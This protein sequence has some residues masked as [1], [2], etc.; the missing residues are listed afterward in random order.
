MANTA[1]HGVDWAFV[2]AIREAENGPF[3]REFGVE[4]NG[5][6]GYDAQLEACTATVTHRLETYPSNPLVRCYGAD[7]FSRIRYTPSFI[8]YFASVWAPIG[9]DNDPESL[10]RNWFR[11]ASNAYQRFV[12]SD[13]SS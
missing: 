7:G 8:A 4:T 12:D 5:I 3:G 6:V 10:N 13:L 2:A 9:A 1:A 11:N